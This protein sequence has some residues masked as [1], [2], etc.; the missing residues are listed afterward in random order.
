MAITKYSNVMKPGPI[1]RIGRLILGSLSISFVAGIL[2]FYSDFINVNP[3]NDFSPYLIGVL[4]A[5]LVLND[6][7]NI[8]FNV[9]WRKRPQ[10]IFLALF[11]IAMALDVLLYGSWWGAPLGIVILVMSLFTHLY[12]GTSHVLAAFIATPGCEMRSIP[13]LFAK[14]NGQ[15]IEGVVCPGHWDEVDKWESD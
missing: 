13:H 4:I 10:A 5:F 12:L 14:L 9:S 7:V 3:I 2:P 15:D 11:L 8:G 1:G 6:V